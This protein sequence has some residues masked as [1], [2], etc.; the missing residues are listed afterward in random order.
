KA[1]FA[2][3]KG[4][5]TSNL[6]LYSN[7]LR[8]P[9]NIDVD[10]NSSLNYELLKNLN[11]TLLLNVFYDDDVLVQITDYDFPNGVNGLGNRVNVAQQLLL[12]YAV[13]F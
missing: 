12:T 10:W 13:T 9:Q 11:L 2:G 3:E 6:Q 1:S 4:S 7:Y 5:F 8:N